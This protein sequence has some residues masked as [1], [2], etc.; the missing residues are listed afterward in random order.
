VKASYQVV[1]QKRYAVAEGFLRSIRE[2]GGEILVQDL[3]HDGYLYSDWDEFSRRVI[4]INQYGRQYGARGFRAGL[5]YRN[6]DWYHALDFSYDMSIP[7]VAHL[8]PQHGGCC[9]VMPY[10]LNGILEIPVT[11]IQDYS[12]FYILNDYSIDLWR[13]QSSIIL[14]K[15]GLM[16][17]IVHPDYITDVKEQQVYKD[18]LGYLAQLRKEAGVWITT[19][20][21]INR[22]WR[23]RAAMQLVEGRRGW[24]IEGAGSE[25][26]CIACAAEENGRLVLSV[27]DCYSRESGV[28]VAAA[29][30]M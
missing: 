12:L 9:T 25:R 16:N 22:W 29:G 7:N 2:R 19:P 5:M 20:G 3:N 13:K 1:P 15:H 28:A 30:G 17:F 10:F 4:L 11:V 23:Q 14:G 8:D 27:Q 24:R 18:L 26:A 21:E 6:Q